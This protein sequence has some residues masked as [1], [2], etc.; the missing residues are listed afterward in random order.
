MHPR[1][2]LG[3]LLGTVALAAL[4]GCASAPAD[5]ASAT[6]ATNAVCPLMGTEADPAYTVQFDGRDIALCCDTC[7]DEWNGMS[8]EAR[9]EFLVDLR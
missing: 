9:R 5:D 4:V 3:S 7:V 2:T 8:D 1:T 6:S